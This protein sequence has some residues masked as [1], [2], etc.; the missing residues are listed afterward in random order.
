MK[1]I[2]L[3]QPWA[4]AIAL[5]YKRFETRGW[6][7]GYRGEIAIHAAKRWTEAE[8]E[9]AFDFENEFGI[10][11]LM[12]PPLGAMLAICRL[13]HVGRTEEVVTRISEMERAF[14]NYAPG[15]FAWRLELIEKFPAPI[16]TKGEQGLF[17]WEPVRIPAQNGR[18]DGK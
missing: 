9:A 16:T 6:C 18:A 11:G 8:R 3:W 14:G 4:S 10:T 7:T 13:T 17:N 15:R 12:T 2:S 5:G 1:A